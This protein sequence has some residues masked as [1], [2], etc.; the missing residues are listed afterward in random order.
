MAGLS[1]QQIHQFQLKLTPDDHSS[2][3][4]D[5]L[6]PKATKLS[7]DG[8]AESGKPARILIHES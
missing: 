4:L 1:A 2:P 7:E 8:N 5:A 3:H 6:I